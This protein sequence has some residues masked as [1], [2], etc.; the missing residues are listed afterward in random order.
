MKDTPESA[1]LAAC[2]KWL[3][4]NNCFVWRHNTG[5]HKHS[6]K[7]KDGSF[8]ESYIR[9]GLL[10]S[11]DIIGCNPHGR[12][13]AIETKRAGKPLEPHQERFKERVLEHHGVFILAH[14][15]DDLEANKNE[16]LGRYTHLPE[17]IAWGIR[18]QKNTKQSMSTSM[19]TA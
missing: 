8:G 1:I 4:L 9:Y 11:A 14:S 3:W 2:I 19:E 6:Y 18:P 16:I 13:L 12:F 17:D 15:V 10:G 5:N 7:R